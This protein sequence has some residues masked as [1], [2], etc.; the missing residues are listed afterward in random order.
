[1]LNDNN[2]QE[3]LNF[4]A[5]HLWHPYT[6]E[7]TAKANLLVHKAYE[8]FIEIIDEN[9]ETKKI[10]DAISS[11]WVNIHGHCNPYIQEKI[12]SQLAK[13][14]QVIFAGFTHE[15]A[16]ELVAKLMKV[17]PKV[18]IFCDENKQRSLS[19]AFFSDNGSTAVEVAI[20]MAIQYFYNKNQAKKNRVI[21]FKNAYHGDTVGTMSVGD[22]STFHHAFKSI[23]FPVDKVSCPHDFL[24][25]KKFFSDTDKAEAEQ[26][27]LEALIKEIESKDNE[28][29]ALIIE[30]LVQ[31]AGGMKFHSELFLQKIREI[32]NHYE[33]LLIADEVFTGFGRTG[34]MFAC[35]QASI[36]PDMICLSK[37]LTAGFMPMGL[38]FTTEE[39]YSAFYD[40]SR[41]KTFFHGHSYTG[42]SL[43]CAAGIASLDLF[44]K[45][46]RL[47][48]IEYLNAKMQNDL[49]RD[50]FKNLS[51]VKD[52]R[53]RGAIAVIEFAN[54]HEH[55]YLSELGPRIY[56]YFLKRN[57][58]LRPL[59]NVLY[60]LPPYTIKNDS[61]E[62][63][64]Q[65]IQNFSLDL[66]KSFLTTQVH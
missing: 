56:E 18:D 62:Y 61:L 2:Y 58:L 44:A 4:D 49:C 10:I 36:V 24:E 11:W 40:D 5:E 7:K 60:F 15:L 19:K 41:L 59:G 29:A 55:A 17:L 25:N 30:P 13:H 1:M 42:N 20:K 39:V 28:H 14:E 65:Q 35:E 50:E 8:E 31:G 52:I 21:T 45:T 47:K 26:Q 33:I 57:I 12:K 37:G 22:T 23:L 53:V 43:A 34:T 66:E 64:L 51:V 9:G 38:T 48:D 63:C 3:Y 6:Q 32:C 46:E 16:I 54:N 27:A